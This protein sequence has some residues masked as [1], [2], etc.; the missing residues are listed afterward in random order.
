MTD[1]AA[2][3]LMAGVA[4]AGGHVGVLTTDRQIFRRDGEPWLWLGCSQF[5]LCSIFEHQGPAAVDRILD[6]YPGLRVPRVW[7]Y[8]GSGWGARAWNASPV[9]CWIDFLGYLRDRGLY[10]NRTALTDDDPA[11]LEPAKRTIEAITAAGCDNVL[12]ECGNEPETHKAI[13]THALIGVMQASGRLWSTGNYENSHHWRGTHG[14]YH[15]ARTTDFARRAH[16]AV[17]Y[18]HG[19]GPNNPDEPA[20]RVPWVNDEPAKLQDVPRDW[21]AWRSH[22]AAS[23]LFGSGFTMHSETGKFGELPTDDERTLWSLALEVLGQI[24]P[25]AALGAYRRIDA[26][27]EPGQTALG[28][29]YVIGNYMVR[30]QQRGTASPEAGW[31]PLDDVGVLFTR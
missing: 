16:D 11:R 7:D 18:F 19:G 30:C 27:H 4:G 20:C 29:T 2:L 31:R 3:L 24:A 22:I 23:F 28:R 26:E 10:C 6:A 17:E 12:H 15:P 1:A 25:D 9:S 5:P 14:L 13:D 8:V 21:V